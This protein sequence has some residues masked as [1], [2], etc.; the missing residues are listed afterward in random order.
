LRDLKGVTNARDY[1][2]GVDVTRYLLKEAATIYFLKGATRDLK[3]GIARDLKK[4]SA[5][6][7]VAVAVARDKWFR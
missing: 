2:K 4:V 7:G 1:F 5:V 6:K 3:G